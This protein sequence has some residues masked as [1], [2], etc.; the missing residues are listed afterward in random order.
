MQHYESMS[1]DEERELNAILRGVNLQIESILFPHSNSDTNELINDFE[2]INHENRKTSENNRKISAVIVSTFHKSPS[3]FGYD[4]MGFGSRLYIHDRNSS[5]VCITAIYTLVQSMFGPDITPEKVNLGLN[6]HFMFFAYLLNLLQIC[7]IHIMLLGTKENLTEHIDKIVFLCKWVEILKNH[8]GKENSPIES[9]Q[10]FTKY[11]DENPSHLI[12]YVCTDILVISSAIFKNSMEEDK[13][14]PYKRLD[15]D[16]PYKWLNW[17]HKYLEKIDKDPNR[18][19]IA[20]PYYDSDD[21]TVLLKADEE[22]INQRTE[23][24]KQIIKDNISTYNAKYPDLATMDEAEREFRE[25]VTANK[26]GKRGGK[27]RRQ[28]RRRRRRYTKKR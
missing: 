22:Q 12:R 26:V 13:D 20:P 21:L 25:E 9:R 1:V 27:T 18:H 14:N 28:K 8:F 7:M 15:K 17:Y 6:G 16:N 23:K 10:P 2:A 3:T 5:I 4:V 24:T 19:S 11:S